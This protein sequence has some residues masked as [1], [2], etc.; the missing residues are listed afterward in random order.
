MLQEMT[1][2]MKFEK[3]CE[4]FSMKKLVIKTRIHLKT[5]GDDDF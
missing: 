3:T 2:V 5:F 4:D 1:K